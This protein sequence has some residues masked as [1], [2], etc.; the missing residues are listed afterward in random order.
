MA[1]D[2]IDFGPAGAPPR[3]STSWRLGFLEKLDRNVAVPLA[4][5]GALA[6]MASLVGPWQK[7]EGRLTGLGLDDQSL[8]VDRTGVFGFMFLIGL[9]GLF[10]L[11]TVALFAPARPRR[12]AALAG[13]GL[14]LAT[15]T[16][17]VVMIYKLTRS[18]PFFSGISTE[19]IKFT[20]GWGIYAAAAS[21]VAF[22]LSMVAMRPAVVR[23]APTP[24]PEAV[25]DDIELDVRVEPV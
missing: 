25:T 2:I 22:G 24:A 9:M 1:E 16:F 23:R 12:V 17:V 11:V 8:T 4:I 15:L 18:S 21:I 19:Q 14:A 6:A 3:T 13:C 5:A 7:L 10:T 20:L